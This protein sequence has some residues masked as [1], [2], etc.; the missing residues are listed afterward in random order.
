M[1]FAVRV[2]KLSKKY[3]DFFALDSINLNVEE[4]RLFA[5]L[6]PN[7]AGKTTL[8]RILTTQLEPTAGEAFVLEKNVVGQ[9][10]MY[11]RR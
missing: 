4:G 11:L 10:T 8:M 5:I 1:N 9:G 3:G 7:G 6:G 2:H